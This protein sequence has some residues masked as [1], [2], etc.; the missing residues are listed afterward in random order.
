MLWTL[1]GYRSVLQRSYKWPPKRGVGYRNCP[2]LFARD[3]YFFSMSTSTN[4][5][6]LCA[7]R[8]HYNDVIMSA[9]ASQIVSLT[10]VYSTIY[11]GAN[12]R[13]HHNSLSL[14]FVRGIQL[15]PENSLHKGPVTRKIFPFDYVVAWGGGCHVM[16]SRRWL[17]EMFHRIVSINT[18]CIS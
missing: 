6:F 11:S 10:I 1:G 16:F 3:V 12:Q 8:N 7:F 14:A 9:I 17:L 15:W 18:L 5:Y 2:F 4:D 13:K